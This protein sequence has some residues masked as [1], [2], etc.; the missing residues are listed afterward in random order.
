MQSKKKKTEQTGITAL[1]C[2]LS[3]DDGQAGDSNSV[4]NQKKLLTK[5]AKE[6]KFENPRFYVDDGDMVDSSEGE[7]ELAP[8]RNV[9]NEMYA[10]DI[11]RKVRSSH[12]IRGNSGEPL[13]Q[14]PYGYMKSPDNPKKWIVDPVAS[15]VVRDIFRLY[16]EGNGTETISRL[17]EER[18]ELNCTAYW[19]SKG[20][21]RGG[22]KPMED[23]YHWK[24]S[25]IHT[26]L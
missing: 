8:F 12:R 20:V 23:P 11:S 21:K 18:K 17:L 10:R 16:L 2:R 3:R 13:S 26:K 5:F 15:L 19:K 14:P 24:N 9:M 6:N 7:N 25:T 22:K 1:Y 4:A